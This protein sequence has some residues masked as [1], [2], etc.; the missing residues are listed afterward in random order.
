MNFQTILPTAIPLGYFEDD[1]IDF[2]V[3][4]LDEISRREFG[5]PVK[6]ARSG[7]IRAM[8]RIGE[9]RLESIP[10][11][12]QRVIMSMMSDFRLYQKELKR[13]FRWEENYI[14]SQ[15]LF[16]PFARRGPD[17]TGIK[18][19]QTNSGY[20]WINNGKI[21]PKAVSQFYFT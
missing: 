14:N 7:L 21:L 12:N 3:K 5:K 17:L 16:D 4:T 18:F 2:L 9:E 20:G 11:M 8:Q 10:R 1:N 15:L 6:F 13:N 19:K